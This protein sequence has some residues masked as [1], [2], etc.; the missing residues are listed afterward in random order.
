MLK[1]LSINR[2]TQNIG[3]SSP[4]PANASIVN[5]QNC[6]DEVDSSISTIKSPNLLSKSASPVSIARRRL[7]FGSPSQLQHQISHS[8]VPYP[9][10]NDAHPP[11]A[12]HRYELST[13]SHQSSPS[14][15][16]SPNKWHDEENNDR[17]IQSSPRGRTCIKQHSVEINEDS[18]SI[19]SSPTSLKSTLSKHSHKDSTIKIFAQSLSQDVEYLT[20]QVTS[21]TKSKHIVRTLLRKFR[22]K[23]RD[24]NLFYLTLERWIRIDGLKSKNIMLLSDDACP[25]QLQQC[26]SNPPHNDIK[27]SLQ[28][29]TGAL[30]KIYCSDVV[31][32]ARYK[33]LS[34][35]T[36]T[37]VDETIELMLHCLNLNNS[38]SQGTMTNCHSGVDATTLRLT[39]SPSSTASSNSSSSGV[40]SDPSTNFHRR[41]SSNQ[42]IAIPTSNQR[43][44]SN[45]RASSVTSI[46][47]TSNSSIT[48]S[49]ELID[50][51]CLVIEC[52][53]TNYR[54]MLNSDEYLVDVYQSLLAEA[55]GQKLKEKDQSDL[56]SINNDIQNQGMS[57]PDQWFLIKLMKREDYM[58][59]QQNPTAAVRLNDPRKEPPRIPQMPTIP[60]SLLDQY[61]SDINNLKH[62]VSTTQIEV[63]NRRS[64]SSNLGSSSFGNPPLANLDAANKA[65]TLPPQFILLPPV[66]PRRRNLS[67]ASST[68]GPPIMTPVV[69]SHARDSRRRYDPARLAEDL[70]KLDLTTDEEMTQ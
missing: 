60:L 68:F 64:N 61:N 63:M 31:R 14:I 20:L 37:T 17:I 2:Q 58:S 41:V 36:Q 34:L 59:R 46:S 65:T 45:S 19:L 13:S 69:C 21:Q 47:T 3:Q 48:L 27:F 54:R 15:N 12:L 25:L 26:C 56:T 62:I 50:Q 22:L 10:E 52:R 38:F 40:E 30:V 6:C 55:R 7:N 39:G 42:H 49:S 57:N 24:P 8:I 11:I 66:K 29:R 18:Q 28:M 44:D 16:L 43:L 23:H 4:S 33:C 32:D 51:Y 67:N 70:S 53:D 9:E 35:S 5:T 1:H